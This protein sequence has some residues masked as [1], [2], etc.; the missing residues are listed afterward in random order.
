M[1]GQAET[2]E[3][4]V[5]E[6][7]T[8]RTAH[9]EHAAMLYRGTGDYLSQVL[10][11][12]TAGLDRDDPVLAAVPGP[13]IAL[14]RAALDGQAGRV[15]FAD[16]TSMGANPA[17]IIPRVRAF[18]D[19]YPGRPVRYVGEPIWEPRSVA[20]LTEATRH[21]ALINLAFAGTDASILCPYD[22]AR[23]APGVIADAER[24][25]PVVV[26]DGRARPSGAYPPAGLFPPGCDQPLPP[27][28]PDAAVLSYR[29]DLAAVRA[30]VARH[31]RVAG[32]PPGRTRD[33]VI[34]ASELAANTLRH[35]SADGTLQ[36]WSAGRELQ[37]QVCDTGHIADP[38]VG[39]RVLPPEAASGHGTW[40]V[41]QICDLVELRTGPG[42][43]T[44]RLHMRLPA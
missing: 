22:S 40:V 13:K 38:L 44:I 36:V 15:G 14:L 23:L 32:L 10:G 19:S 27:P 6:P 8:V 4:P 34:A 17:W 25:H 21:E 1:I 29:D 31:A 35:T 20:E 30:F 41:H 11:F 43:T 24:T 42:G 18:V 16:M 7:A 37:C 3:V 2:A 26:R 33:L 39:R 28:P 5:R 9:L 12:V